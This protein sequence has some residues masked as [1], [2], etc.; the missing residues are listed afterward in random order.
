MNDK[1]AFTELDQLAS[2]LPQKIKEYTF[3]KLIGQGGFSRVFLVS[4][5]KYDFK[6]CAK[7]MPKSLQTDN[8]NDIDFLLHLEHPNIIRIY[9]QFVIGPMIYCI[10]EYCP[11]GSLHD[12]VQEGKIKR[13][14]EIIFQMQQ[15]LLALN[16][17]HSHH[18]AHRDIKPSNILID[19][20]GRPKLIDFG[21]SIRIE[22]G[23]LIREFSGSKAYSP[24]E[25]ILEQPYNPYKADIWSLGVTFYFLI[26]TKLPWPKSPEKVMTTAIEQ[27][28]YTLPKYTP[29]PF[30]KLIKSMLQ[31]DPED[32]PSV[33]S[34]LRLK[35]F[36]ENAILRPLKSSTIDQKKK[37]NSSF[38]S[39]LR[40]EKPP[41]KA[42]Q[43]SF[44]VIRAYSSRNR[45]LD[46]APSTFQ[47]TMTS[48]DMFHC[49]EY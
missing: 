47:P 45:F 4:S 22:P 17:V 42:N 19:K 14:D 32:R 6:F 15:I 24:P 46:Q 30:A 21:I 36:P 23:E 39:Q 18:I 2:N 28:Q 26:I 33:K 5:P 43:S 31:V 10:L 38:D 9:D 1:V 48:I 29:P 25:V 49:E 40:Y 11:N 8:Q 34:L 41:K 44:F 7:V 35:L 20:Y 37:P 13:P 16:F 27:A 3:E 12:I